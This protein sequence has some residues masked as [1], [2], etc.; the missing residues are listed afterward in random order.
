MTR[1]RNDLKDAC[2]HDG[3]CRRKA[4]VAPL[5]DLHDPGED[6]I[7]PFDGASS[8]PEDVADERIDDRPPRWLQLFAALVVAALALLVIRGGSTTDLADP[9]VSSSTFAPS[10]TEAPTPSTTDTS[11]ADRGPFEEPSVRGQLADGTPFVVTE[12]T[13]GVLCAVIDQEE[14]CHLELVTASGAGLIDDALVFGYLRPGT[15]FAAVRYRST[16]TSSEGLEVEPDARFF[17]L[18]LQ[19]SD[20]YRLQYR[21]DGIQDEVPLVALEGGASQTPEAAVRDG[22]PLSIAERSFGDRVAV[23]AEWTGFAEGPIVWSRRPTAFTSEP[24]WGELLLLDP[25]GT[26]IERSTPLPS[27]RLTAQIAQPEALFFLGEQIATPDQIAVDRDEVRFPIVVVRIDRVTGEHLVRVFPQAST[28]AEPTIAP[29]VDRDA[30]E[31]GP[32][33]PAV[34]PN[35]M[36]AVDGGIKIGLVDGASLLLDTSSLLPVS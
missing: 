3:P 9:S 13:P 11:Q 4:D 20:A 18:P 12:T 28:N 1:I 2:N 21:G 22:V 32:E 23:L 7:V 16:Q 19:A 26:Q 34:D 36:G 29:L 14:T 6:L 24:S 10:T 5:D 30:W 8:S 27:V 33:L 17:A 25:T 35:R 31:L 15:E